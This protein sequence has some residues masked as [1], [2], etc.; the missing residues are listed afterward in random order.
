MSIKLTGI[1]FGVTPRIP[2]VRS[3]DLAAVDCDNPST[4]LAG[5]R[6]ILRQQSVFFISPPGWLPANA[7]RPSERDAAGPVIVHEVP[8]SEAYLQWQDTDGDVEAFLKFTSKYE[9]QPLGWKPAP[10]EAPRSILA[11]IPA[12]QLGD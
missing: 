10:F 5:W 4:A 8:R 9:S 12:N 7:G 1:S 3:G 2:G 6:I 11:Q